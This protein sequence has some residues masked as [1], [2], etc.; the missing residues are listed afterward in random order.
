MKLNDIIIYSLVGG[1]SIAMG[2]I[3]CSSLLLLGK[4]IHYISKKKSSIPYI[5]YLDLPLRLSMAFIVPFLGAI[6]PM[7]LVASAGSDKS[8]LKALGSVYLI[9]FIISLFITFLIFVRSGKIKIDTK[10]PINGKAGGTGQPQT[11]DE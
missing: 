9:G 3:I 8:I 7:M 4:A 10:R 1:I 6:V 11:R 5:H 2:V